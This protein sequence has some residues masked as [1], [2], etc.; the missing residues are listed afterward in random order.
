VLHVPAVQLDCKV[1]TH[2]CQKTKQIKHYTT[3]DNPNINIVVNTGEYNIDI[4]LIR[5]IDCC[6]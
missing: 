2:L 1:I 5:M 6:W 4:V 3:F